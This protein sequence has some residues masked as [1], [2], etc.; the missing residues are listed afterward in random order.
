MYQYI[1][2]SYMENIAK[3]PVCNQGNL[4]EGAKGYMCN[5]FKSIDDKCSFTIFKTYFGKEMT[6]KIVEQLADQKETDFFDDLINKE[7][8]P[9]SAKLVIDDGIIKPHFQDKS[10]DTPCPKCGK[11]VRISHK[12]F[13]CEDFFNNKECDLYINRNVAGVLLSENEAEVLLNGSST[14]Y[15]IDFLSNSQ[16]TFGAK[17]FLD[18]SFQVKFDFELTKCPK[19]KTGSIS[20]NP[21][22]YGCSNYKNDQIRCEFTVWREISG[23]KISLKDFLDLCQKGK[24]DKTQF[25]PKNSDEYTGSIS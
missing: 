12:T 17:L 6:W 21:W 14:D 4:I 19:C 24:S 22:A 15:R 7:N 23:K 16:K 9:F 25:K 20:V 18:D 2:I 5:H 13:I 3:C 11:Q 8:K 1:N 10:L